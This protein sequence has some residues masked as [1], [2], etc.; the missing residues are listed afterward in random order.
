MNKELFLSKA[1]T[2]CSHS[3]RCIFDLQQKFKQ[4]D[5]PEQFW[6]SIVD[7][8]VSD[9]FIDESRYASAFVNDKIKFNSW[10]KQ[11]VRYHLIQKGIG[12]SVIS[13]CLSDFPDGEYYTIAHRLVARKFQL[14]SGDAQ[15]YNKIVRYMA[16]KGF[17]YEL[18]SQIIR[19][20]EA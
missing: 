20:L 8:L 5:V 3:E 17:D 2:Y 7:V 10:G 18:V 4:W 6:D 16:G 9:G 15:M 11:K 1:M 12:S 13:A 14:L 19:D